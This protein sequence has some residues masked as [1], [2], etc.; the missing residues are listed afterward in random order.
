MEIQE[1]HGDIVYLEPIDM[2]ERESKGGIVYRV[3]DCE[4]HVGKVILATNENLVGKTVIY[5]DGSARYRNKERNIILIDAKNILATVSIG[6]KS[7]D[8]GN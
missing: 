6:G 4:D 1:V 3:A 2:S 7:D 8:E 5:N